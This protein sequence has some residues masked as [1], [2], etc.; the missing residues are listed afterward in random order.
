MI[1]V[2]Q[3]KINFNPEALSAINYIIGLVIFGVALDMKL[4]DFK[5]VLKMPKAPLVGLF[6]QFFILPAAAF[7]LVSTVNLAPSIALGV[8]LLA[9]CPGGNLSNFLTNFAKGNTALSVTMSSISTLASVFMLP[10]NLKLWG[11]L[12][13]QTASILQSVDLSFW[14]IFLTILKILIIP[15]ILGMIFAKKFPEITEKIKKPFSIGSII[16]FSGFIFGALVMNKEHFF[17]YIGSFFMI[18]LLTNTVALMIGNIMGRITKL[19]KR[20]IRAISFEIGIQ[21]AALGLVVVF[22][23]FDGLGGMAIVCAWWG[24]WHIVSGLSLATYWAKKYKDPAK[25]SEYTKLKG[26]LV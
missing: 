26:N 17:N 8:I 11:A 19:E 22:N 25:L 20:D 23:F 21:N 13:P 18:V 2:D 9:S 10:F 1:P 7:V 4:E 15:S 6:S 16:I 3:V 24:V 12:N 14:A 5:R